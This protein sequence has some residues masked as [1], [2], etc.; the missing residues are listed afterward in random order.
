ME[1]EGRM[2]GKT[3]ITRRGW[4]TAA[5]A[6]AAA[7]RLEVRAAPAARVQEGVANQ[8]RGVVLIMNT[9]FTESGAVDYESL[10]YEVRFINRCGG[11]AF[12]WGQL[13]P[14]LN[15]EERLRAMETVVKANRGQK[16]IV[17]L[18][19]QGR[20]TAEMLKYAKHAEA[21]APDMIIS[22]PPENGRTQ[23]DYRAYYRALATA[24]KRPVIIQTSGGGGVRLAPS[25]DLI[26]EL[27][28]EFP[29]FG[30][31]KEEAP[32]GKPV[33]IVTRQ[34]ELMSHRPP[35]KS[36]LSANFGFGLLYEMRL[37][38][39]GIVT[40]SAMYTDVLTRM[41]DMHLRGEEDRL[42]EAYGR[43]LLLRNLSEQIP[44]T[45]L[46]LWKKRGVYKTMTTRRGVRAGTRGEY[47]VGETKLTDT[48]IAEIEY[49]FASLKP[50]LAK[51]S[52]S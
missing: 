8:I 35:M 34:K 16:A 28:R 27:A 44:A 52:S 39:D 29:N 17:G 13:D 5:T 7:S 24:T 19:V 3:G 10:A 11:K 26:I 38:I 43:F 42:R 1:P 46:Y 51:E 15:E 45:D 37:G 49:R 30:Y 12:V 22:R 40:G 47:T 2:D 50:Y 14:F 18:G 21:L 41:W 36:V 33:E 4:L 20:D 25:T 32:V 9:P 23:E 48:E 6:A 31:V